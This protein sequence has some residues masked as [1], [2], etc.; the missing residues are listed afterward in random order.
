MR[1]YQSMRSLLIR[2]LGGVVMRG[3]EASP[4]ILACAFLML[5]ASAPAD[6]SEEMGSVHVVRSDPSTPATVFA[7]AERGVFKSIDGGTTW[8]ATGLTQ[9]TVALAIAPVTPTTV[10]AGTGSGLFKS[11]DGGTTWS[12]AGVS[13]Q[14]CSVEIDPAIPTTI[15]ASTCS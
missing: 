3:R 12:T 14:V 5:S 11:V 4:G 15:Y 10:Y 9:G 1:L 8:T 7:G 13:D 6:A 2:L